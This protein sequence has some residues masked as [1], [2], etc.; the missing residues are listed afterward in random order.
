VR[1]GVIARLGAA[2]ERML[3]PIDR[4]LSFAGELLSS[5]GAIVRRPSVANWGAVPRLIERAGTDGLPIVLLL[6]FL[7]GFVMAF[8]SMQQLKLYGAN[9]YV[10]DLVGVSVTRELGP[11]ITAIIITGRSG[12]AYAAELGTMRVSEEIDALRTM[13]ITPV[14]HLV[15]PRVVALAIVA[16]VLTLLGDV[17]G[18]LGGLV[19]AAVSL[20]VTPAG[21]LTELRTIVVASDVW[22]GLI[23]SVAFGA[24]IA[25]IGCQLGLTTRG[26]AS[27][28]GRATTATVVNCLF[29]IVLIDTAFTVV[30]QRFGL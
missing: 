12:A 6:N 14:P 24:A 11:L 15:V 13:G 25:L 4:L 3:Q 29:S 2:V 26:S 8:Q 20:D 28:V 30:F 19:V 16:P 10:A 9:V 18:V 1:E 23:K 21:Y 27:D 7:I 5:L 17:V 22:T